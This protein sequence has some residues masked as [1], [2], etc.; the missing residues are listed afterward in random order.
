VR[1]DTAAARFA[2]LDSEQRVAVLR[3]L[4]AAGRLD[5]IPAVVPRRTGTGPARLS[6]A[7]EDLWV[8]ESL[9][10]GGSSLNLCCSY[11]F[12][13][14]VDVAALVRALTLVRERHEVLRARIEARDDEPCL[15]IDPSVDFPLERTDL[16]ETAVPLA[17]EASAFAT[18]PFDVRGGRLMRGRLVT[19]D[20]R[21]SVLLLALHH[22]ITDWWSFD[23]LHGE[24]AA[25]YQALRE[26]RTPA[27]DPP[28]IDYADFACWQR[29]LAAAGVYEARLAYWRR[30]LA[31][32]PPQLTVGDPVIR[33]GTTRD[34][35]EVE[36]AVDAATARRV[37]EFAREHGSS[38]FHVLMT[39]FAVFAHR[40]SGHCDLVLGTPT[41]NRAVAGLDRLV[42]YV[43][44]ELPTRWRIGPR[45][46]FADLLGRFTAEFPTLLAH[47]DV[48]V[49]RIISAVAPERTPDRPPLF[50]WVFM[51][52]GRH[53]SEAALRRVAEPRRVHT[54]GEHDLVGVTQETDEGFAGSLH[55][56][57]DVYP[58][59]VVRHW[60]ACFAP[61]LSELLAEPTRPVGEARLPAE[62]E[63]WR[64]LPG[65]RAEAPAPEPCSLV[66][67]VAR[68]AAR[69]PA[70]PALETADD[71]LSYRELLR[72]IDALAA[73]L[74]RHGVRPGDYVGI[75]LPRSAEALIAALAAQ[76]AGAAFLP[77][78][79]GH[80]L[81]R[82]RFLLARG[83]ALLLTDAARVDALSPLGVP[84]LPV[85]A[86]DPEACSQ[87]DVM[88]ATA[89]FDPAW[90][91]YVLHT[92]GSS[93]EP[94]G[95]VVSHAG[96]AHL[97]RTLVERFALGP[98]S[99][100]LLAGSPTFDISIAELCMAF[101]SGGTLIVPGR[102]PLVGEELGT[103]LLRHR[104]SCALMPPTVLASVP[105]GDYPDLGR[106]CVGAESCPPDLVARWSSPARS[107]QGTTFHNAYGPTETTVMASLSDPLRATGVEPPIGR[108]VEGTRLYVL[109][110]RL[111]PVPVGVRGELYVAGASLAD[112]Y[113]GRP[114]MTAE[115][116]L[117]DPYAPSAGAR[118]YRTGDLARWRADGQLQFLGR[119]D[120]QVK[121]RGLRVEPGEVR[122]A[123][124]R[125]AAVSQAA[126]IVRDDPGRPRRLVAYLTQRQNAEEIDESELR[127]ALA[128]TLPAAMIP[129]AFVRV[130]ALPMT[131]RGKLDTAA[132]PAPIDTPRAEPTQPRTPREALLCGWFA[133]LLDVTPVGADD[134]FFA[135]GGDSIAAIRLA[136]RAAEAGLAISPHDVFIART[137]AALATTA[138]DAVPAVADRGVGVV[139]LT[140]NMRWWFE[141]DARLDAFTMATLFRVPAGL[142]T[143]RIAAA[144]RGLVERHGVLRMRIDTSRADVPEACV[145]EHA[146]A[147]AGAVTR[148]AASELDDAALLAAARRTAERTRLDPATGRMTAAVWFDRGTDTPG[149]LLL[150]VHHFAV[151]I[152]S[153]SII[154]EEL[155]A[156]L[157]STAIDET[158]IDETMIDGFGRGTS[159]RTWARELWRRVDDAARQLPRWRELIAGPEARLLPETARG[160]HRATY[161]VALPR[162][163]STPLFTSVPAAFDC[164]T[165]AVL[166]TGLLAAAARRRGSGTGLLVDLE[167]HGRDPGDAPIDL[168]RTVGWFTGRFPIRIDAGDCAGAAFWQA[169]ADT[170]RAVTRVAARLRAAPDAIGY[171]ILRHLAPER[172]PELAELP[173]P[174]LAFN[175]LGRS[176]VADGDAVL[177]G[178]AD[179]GLPVA[180]TVQLDVAA[181]AEAEGVRLVATWSYTADTVAAEVIHEL[182]DAWFEALGVLVRHVAERPEHDDA[183]YRDADA[184]DADYRDADG[185]D[186]R[187]AEEREPAAGFPLLDLTPDQIA[188]FDAELADSELAE[189]GLADSEL[190][191]AELDP[192]SVEPD[193]GSARR[194]EP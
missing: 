25:A 141:Q 127:R 23:V 2:A 150:V 161:E 57:T 70:A 30:Y 178:A 36:F 189:S 171:G 157:T 148:V 106:L 124:L 40:L 56:R 188:L 115:R 103:A 27:V 113:L 65:A 12:D 89:T 11:H 120:E 18:R 172:A 51:H 112:G 175:Y 48:P 75:A 41:A 114:G 184:R 182:A 61:L 7:Q 14:P 69:T 5:A 15:V 86:A 186:D 8:F 144:V 143:E 100:V 101:G 66:T 59:D 163:L 193:M 55:V 131:D 177:L 139:P 145:P 151:D 6:P 54:G 71:V 80:P 128:D 95:V 122:A 155:A 170:A 60:A 32:P 164:G 179:A 35:A 9:Y 158:V 79:P 159:F 102:G 116:F 34:N 166:L 192:Q 82:L 126:V 31:E 109:D 107:R 137:P 68:W 134:D 133:E 3:K 110:D 21:R 93:G 187:A 78:D 152:V 123:L 33:P 38:V 73:R 98:A 165:E 81:A 162:E 119:A 49:G 117:A 45:D 104:V 132:L 63:P 183:D 185:S 46:G 190:A 154:G 4:V 121:V 140:P 125:H 176:G 160:T 181:R 153:W 85:D 28:A 111:R 50:Q 26:G 84:V 167:R 105:D 16:R 17:D 39:A 67:L 44:N 77:V 146:G 194:N 99:R 180:H 47:A 72:R 91:A 135:L 22:V 156:S 24:F 142:D 118:M 19:V 58:L 130:D 96:I 1:S 169:G 42:G 64:R 43:M 174:D 37:R 88:S 94:K 136:R 87:S 149:G 92:S 76:R 90:P 191:D 20:Q 52:L 10:P 138:R 129:D 29:E 13:E 168:S 53:R 83:V 147:D 74:R 108:P 97:T 62:P 173:A